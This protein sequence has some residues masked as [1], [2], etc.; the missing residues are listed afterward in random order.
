LSERNHT[1]AF[2][3][4]AL[5]LLEISGKSV[6]QIETD[7]GIT[8]G[9]LNKW[10]QRYRLHPETG[11]VKPSEEREL[12]AENRRLRR[13]LELVKAEHELLKR[14]SCSRRMCDEV[15]A[16]RGGARQLAR[17]A[18]V[19]GAAGVGQR[20]LCV[21]AAAP[22]RRQPKRNE[23]LHHSDRGSQYASFTYQ[24]LLAAHHVTFSMSKTADPY[25]NA[26]MESCIGTL[27][28]ECADHRFPSRQAAR[29]E[30]FAYL[31]GWYNR[32]RLHSA[33]GYLSPDQFEQRFIQ[34]N[35]LF[36]SMG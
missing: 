9:L 21:A 1:T 8:P 12:E 25:D 14:S 36:H 24:Q 18:G 2:K 26:L 29:S 16:H 20:V 13:E 31:E 6:R 32:T 5:R 27:K 23:L 3:Q 4:E 19:S 35:F 11:A 7:L 33:L 17:S 28:T 10:K 30:L 34:D 22:T 15:R